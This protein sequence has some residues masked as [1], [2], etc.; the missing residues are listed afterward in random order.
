MVTPAG[1][2]VS[3]KFAWTKAASSCTEAGPSRSL[4]CRTASS[5]LVVA[6]M[7]SPAITRARSRRLRFTLLLRG[8]GVA[9][10][11]VSDVVVRLF[12]AGTHDRAGHLLH[13]RL[14]GR[15]HSGHLIRLGKD[16]LLLLLPDLHRHQSVPP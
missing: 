7:S 2:R 16:V 12:Q 1:L 4:A 6:T 8:W 15:E 5:L 14:Q 11:Q 9:A 10:R 3:P 13:Q